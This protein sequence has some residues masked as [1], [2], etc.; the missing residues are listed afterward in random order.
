MNSQIIPHTAESTHWYWPDGRPAYEVPGARRQLVNPDIRHAR[1]LGLLP[2]VTT[3]MRVFAKPA[4]ERWL[5]TQYVMAAL[6]LERHPYES[7]EGYMHR[8]DEDARAWT[9]KRA[10]EGTAIHKAIEQAWRGDAYDQQYAEHVSKVMHALGEIGP[11]FVG[12]FKTKDTLEGK[13]ERMLFFDEHVM[14]LAAYRAGIAA[15][16]PA[17]LQFEAPFATTRYG[18]RVDVLQGDPRKARLASIMV[19]MNPASVMV[20]IWTT[21]ESDRGLELFELALRAWQLKNNWRPQA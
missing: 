12:D 18:G 4:L 21:E 9:E 13:T 15:K 14:Q 11:D 8:L 5:R 7:D 19:G 6:T 17:G 10:N 2:S 1:K 16:V 3:V 20:K